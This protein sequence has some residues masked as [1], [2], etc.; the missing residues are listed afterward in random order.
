MT[1]ATPGRYR[2]T[3][4]VVTRGTISIGTLPAGAEIEI[5]QVDAEG[6]KVIGPQLG[7]WRYWDIPAEPLPSP[8]AAPATHHCPECYREWWG[9]MGKR[10]AACSVPLA[11]GPAPWHAAASPAPASPRPEERDV[12][13][14]MASAPPV[15]GRDYTEMPAPSPR[16]EESAD[17][18]TIC[19]CPPGTCSDRCRNCAACARDYYGLPERNDA[20]SDHRSGVGAGSRDVDG[21]KASGRGDVAATGKRGGVDGALRPTV[22]AGEESRPGNGADGGPGTAG[23]R[24]RRG[25]G[26]VATPAPP[27]APTRDGTLPFPDDAGPRCDACKGRGWVPGDCHPREVCGTCNGTGYPKSWAAEEIDRLDREVARLRALQSEAR[28][29][30]LHEAADHLDRIAPYAEDQQ[31]TFNAQGCAREVRLL[32]SAPPRAETGREERCPKCGCAGEVFTRAGNRWARCLSRPG[33]SCMNEW[34]LAPAASPTTES[35]DQGVDR[36]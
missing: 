28:A 27:P 6:H 29:A 9:P 16:P 24:V 25:A 3:E 18:A 26:E 5:T 15:E 17:P 12:L 4:D 22:G 35:T 34:P 30:A 21:S 32:A 13:R 33:S 36:E 7:D 10:C 23:R 14:E 31:T 11:L 20:G 19:T 2:L 8:S 1:I